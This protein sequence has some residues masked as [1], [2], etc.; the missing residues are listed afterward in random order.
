MDCCFVVLGVA[1][2]GSSGRDVRRAA[3]QLPPAREIGV[4]VSVAHLCVNTSQQMLSTLLFRILSLLLCQ[5]LS[6]Q[7]RVLYERVTPAR[8]R[9]LSSTGSSLLSGNYCKLPTYQ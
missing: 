9:G 7:Q 4:S 5:R 1:T 2:D 8:A 3:H 6:I